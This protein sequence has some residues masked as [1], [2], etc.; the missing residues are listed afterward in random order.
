MTL[1]PPG[2]THPRGNVTPPRVTRRSAG[3][4]SC[5]AKTI[6]RKGLV[7]DDAHTPGGWPQAIGA[8]P[9]STSTEV[10]IGGQRDVGALVIVANC[11]KERHRHPRQILHPV[12]VIRVD[13]AVQDQL[14]MTIGAFADLRSHLAGA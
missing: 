14:V 10:M 9:R 11:D 6:A 5:R 2:R 7:N 13:L 4:G 8:K 3:G 1:I 12:P